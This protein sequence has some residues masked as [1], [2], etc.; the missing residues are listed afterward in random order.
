MAICFSILFITNA[1]GQSREVETY[2][3]LGRTKIHEYYTTLDEPPYKKHGVYKE[4]DADGNLIR[5]KEFK[6]GE[7][8][9][10]VR[11]YYFIPD[12]AQKA[13]YG[14]LIGESEWVNGE[15]HGWDKTWVCDQ[16][17][18]TLESEIY[19]QNGVEQKGKFYYKNGN[20]QAEKV[21]TGINKEWDEAGQLIAEYEVTDGVENGSKT[22]WYSNGQLK[23]KGETADGIEIGNWVS[24]F[25]NGNLQYELVLSAEKPFPIS[26]LGY[27]PNGNLQNSFKETANGQYV[28]ED[29]FEHGSLSVR[30]NKK[31]DPSIRELVFHGTL[32]V[33]NGKNE[34]VAGGNFIEGCRVGAFTL[35][36]D[37]DWKEVY[38]FTEA[39][40]KRELVFDQRCKPTGMV[41]DYYISGV[42]QFEGKMTSLDPEVLDG[43]CTFFYPNGNKKEERTILYGIPSKIVK[44]YEHGPVQME[45]NY[46]E[47][48][49]DGKVNYY[50]ENGTLRQS[51]QYRLGLKNGEWK[52]FSE[53]GTLMEVERYRFDQLIDSRTMN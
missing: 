27:Y 2:Y 25:E 8:H 18:I 33:Y 46:S 12:Y 47:G 20:L 40:F 41:T 36:Y 26:R 30:A 53:N 48:K 19:Y 22:L 35:L 21:P 38:N 16:G 24:Y 51:E 39:A 34:K 9:G 32:E 50:D 45:A 52:Y 13:C 11:V 23:A 44:Y 37:K 1:I 31:Y 43:L 42:K 7:Q 10:M 14:K 4:F 28:M 29:Y 5:Y 17:N 15:R 49:L 3:D 6:N